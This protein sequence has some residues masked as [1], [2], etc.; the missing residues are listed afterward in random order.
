MKQ[1]QRGQDEALSHDLIFQAEKAKRAQAEARDLKRK[2]KARKKEQRAEDAGAAKEMVPQMDEDGTAVYDA[3]GNPVLVPAESDEPENKMDAVERTMRERQER[4]E[5]QAELDGRRKAHD[6]E[7]MEVK[8]RYEV[9]RV[10]KWKGDKDTEKEREE[11]RRVEMLEA[12]AI[13]KKALATEADA[14]S[15]LGICC[16]VLGGLK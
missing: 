13:K 11:T 16:F 15:F 1:E 8:S 12:R 4:E 10:E 14:V 2:S 7:V 5:H 9:E 6:D 3:D